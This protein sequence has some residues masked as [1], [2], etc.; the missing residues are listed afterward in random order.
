MN[1]RAH[2]IRNLNEMRDDA[3]QLLNL[4]VS[5][6]DKSA[7]SILTIMGKVIGVLENDWVGNDAILH[8]RSFIAAYNDMVSLRN[9]LADLAYTAINV[10][11]VYIESQNFNANGGLGFTLR[12]YEPRSKLP[13]YNGNPDG[14]RITSAS[15]NQKGEIST[16]LSLVSMFV[17]DV[18]KYC[19]KLEDNWKQGP[20]RDTLFEN[21]NTYKSELSSFES[22][23]SDISTAISKAIEKYGV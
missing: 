14:L 6:M 11:D 23:L 22:I 15:G 20:G 19:V 2:E 12:Q 10:A 7:D 1:G 8:I 3:N 16:I 17:A 18:D 13:E 5:T 4:A 9:A 21:Y